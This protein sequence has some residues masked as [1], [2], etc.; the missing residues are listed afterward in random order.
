M[1]ENLMEDIY[2]EY[3]KNTKTNDLFTLPFMPHNM[4]HVFL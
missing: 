2:W 3:N 4:K 1:S